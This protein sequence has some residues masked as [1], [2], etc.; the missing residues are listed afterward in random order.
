MK[1]PL[2]FVLPKR[3]LTPQY[4]SSAFLVVEITFTQVRIS[5]YFKL[6]AIESSNRTL[7]TESFRLE[8]Q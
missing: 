7:P 4:L 2:S 3:L 1:A 8:F 6:E 5:S